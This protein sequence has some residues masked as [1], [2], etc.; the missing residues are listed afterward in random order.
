MVKE[1]IVMVA[2]I[3]EVMV[4]FNESAK[5]QEGEKEE[6]KTLAM[7]ATNAYYVNQM[8][9]ILLIALSA[10]KQVM[11]KTPKW[12]KS[13]FVSQ[14]KVENNKSKEMIG[15]M[16]NNLTPVIASKQLASPNPTSRQRRIKMNHLNLKL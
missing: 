3:V 4:T 13:K 2:L 15:I 16:L 7:N 1:E 11:K 9:M 8:T 5:T 14:M 6:G 10:R 12:L